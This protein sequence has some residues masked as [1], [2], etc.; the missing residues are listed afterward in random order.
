VKRLALDLAT[1]LLA[2]SEPIPDLLVALGAVIQTVSTHQHFSVARRQKPKHCRY[3]VPIL[4]R[5][6]ARG[7]VHGGLVSH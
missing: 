2:D 7:R 3:L 5:D 4:A 6:R 1:A